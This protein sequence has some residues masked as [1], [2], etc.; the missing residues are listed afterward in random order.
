MPARHSRCLAVLVLGAITGPLAAQN[1]A[2]APAAPLA[3]RLAGLSAV[4]GFETVLADSIQSLLPGSARDRAGNVVLTIGTGPGPRRL[5]ACPMDEPGM[6]V[7][8]V[9]DDGWLTL[10]RAPGRASALF[11]QAFEGH[12]ISVHAVRG[13]VPG[14][15]GVRSIHL[16]RGRS[17]ADEPFTAD[18]A[19]VDVG[20][21]SRAQVEA[22]GIQRLSPVTLEKRPYAWGAD[23]VAAPFMGRRAACAALV[24]AARTVAARSGMTPSRG[25]VVVAFVTGEGTALS[26]AQAMAALHGDFAETVLVDG[27]DGPADAST[28]QHAPLA[29]HLGAISVRT[30]AT[31]FAGT[32]VES[33]TTPDV[34]ALAAELTGLLGGD[35]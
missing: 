22:L 23:L 21:T 28:L 13:P 24:S 20:A 29:P 6:V 27:P 17:V 8:E 3:L 16:A 14:V 18:Q 10:R 35:K 19:L 15:V 30:L 4:T 33:V 11:D 5:V 26:G 25:S 12:R 9:R 2:P 34:T 1:A 7:G 31:R 32:P